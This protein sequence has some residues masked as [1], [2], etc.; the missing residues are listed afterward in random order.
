[1]STLMRAG[2]V[3]M[4]ATMATMI[5]ALAGTRLAVSAAQRLD[6][7]TAPSRLNAYVIREADVMHEIVQKNCPTV[8]IR[9]TVPAQWEP[10][11]ALK[12]GATP[13][14]ASALSGWPWALFGI[15]N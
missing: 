6:P 12:I 15:A 13:P 14:P 11:A 9:S 4:A 1:M 3:T 8:E 5:T 2:R 10:S 7:G